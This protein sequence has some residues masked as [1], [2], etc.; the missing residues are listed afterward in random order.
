MNSGGMLV[1]ISLPMLLFAILG[2]LCLRAGVKKYPKLAGIV[3]K[4]K[5]ALFFSIFIRSTIIA[6]LSLCVTANFGGM[7]NSDSNSK[8][9]NYPVMIVLS[10]IIGAGYF[11]ATYV[12]KQELDRDSTQALIGSAY[13]GVRTR[14]KGTMIQVPLFFVRRLLFVLAMQC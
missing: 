10:L 12:E 11:L 4:L 2:F 6:Y 3:A 7:F 9:A 8:K 13:Q 14:Y 1:M 5:K